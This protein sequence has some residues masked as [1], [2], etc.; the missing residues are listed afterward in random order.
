MLDGGDGD[1]GNIFEVW[2]ENWPALELFVAC[3]RQW[4]YG[5]MGG[6]LGL[7]AEGVEV[8]MRMKRVPLKEQWP[9]FEDLQ[10]MADEALTVLNKKHD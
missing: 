2:P 7:R 5:A 10:A 1:D 8:V 4:S 9:L 6:V 3:R